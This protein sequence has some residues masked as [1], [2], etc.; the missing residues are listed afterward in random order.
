MDDIRTNAGF[1]ITNAIPIGNKE[2]VLGVNMKNDQSFVTWECKDKNDYFWGHYTTSLLA[3]TK[4]LCQ[5]VMS[6][7]EYLEQRDTQQKTENR[8]ILEVDVTHGDNHTVL[9]LPTNEL[10]SVLE[11]IGITLPP[12]QVRLGGNENISVCLRHDTNKMV[13]ALVHL[14]K[15]SDNLFMINEVVKAVFRSDNLVYDWVEKRL[16][17]DFYCSTEHLLKDAINYKK[18]MDGDMPEQKKAKGNHN[19]ER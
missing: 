5:R 15:A 16:E 14:F 13:G 4:D 9:Q 10:N 17:R 7:I 6:E 18:F 1:V 2:F 12:Q 11:S 19:Q 3:A 8:Y